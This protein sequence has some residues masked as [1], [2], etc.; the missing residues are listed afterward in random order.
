MSHSR[1]GLITMILKQIIMFA[2][3]C[4]FRK[5]V[6]I[7][8]VWAFW[9]LVSSAVCWDTPCRN[10]RCRGEIRVFVL[11]TRRTVDIFSVRVHRKSDSA[12]FIIKLAHTIH[13]FKLASPHRRC[14][15]SFIFV[16]DRQWSTTMTYEMSWPKALQTFC[17]R[18][19]EFAIVSRWRNFATR[20][21]KLCSP[22]KTWLFR[23]MR[24]VCRCR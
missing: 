16:L 20:R 2:K 24:T 15:T 10:S 7:C 5:C 17:S 1:S 8:R 9:K 11:S 21:W 6:P 13:K 18:L 23:I 22:T 3:R 4:R 19:F 12:W 14:C